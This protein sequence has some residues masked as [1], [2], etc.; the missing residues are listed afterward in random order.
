MH[1]SFP[2]FSE[3][4]LKPHGT[5]QPLTHNYLRE[6]GEGSCPHIVVENSDSQKAAHDAKF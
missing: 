1:Q 3:E 2:L 5:H 6:L 4:A